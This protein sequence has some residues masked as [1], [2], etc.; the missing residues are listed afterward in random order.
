MAEIEQQ[1]GLAAAEGPGPHCPD[2]EGGAGVVAEGQQALTLP[3]G[4]GAAAFHV[5]DVG[6]PQ[7][8]AAGEADQQ[9]RGPGPSDAVDSG[10]QGCQ[11]P[12]QIARQPQPV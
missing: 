10:G 7:G 4:N 12:P 6:C 3:G 11:Q 9:R 2:D 5:G 8:I 1:P